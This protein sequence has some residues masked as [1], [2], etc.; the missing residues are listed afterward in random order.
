MV[1][2][3]NHEA[4]TCTGCGGLLSETTDPANDGAYLIEPAVRCH[5]CTVLSIARK[6]LEE[7]SQPE[8][9]YPIVRKRGE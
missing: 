2:L 7:H 6:Q 3:A 1:A 9:M 4:D 8:A 5:R